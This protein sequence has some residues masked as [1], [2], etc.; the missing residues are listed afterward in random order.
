MHFMASATIHVI[1]GGGG[2]SPTIYRRHCL[3]YMR[4]TTLH[5]STKNDSGTYENSTCTG[6]FTKQRNSIGMN[7]TNWC[8]MGIAFCFVWY[9]PVLDA[10][11][12]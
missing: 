7:W 11:R 10:M 9:A 12:G 6:F 8:V 5:C 4:T 2:Y 1:V 3:P